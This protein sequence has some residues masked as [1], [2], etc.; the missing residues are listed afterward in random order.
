MKW[1]LR[2]EFGADSHKT[3]ARRCTFIPGFRCLSILSE[4]VMVEDTAGA[5][6]IID[7]ENNFVV[8]VPSQTNKCWL[9]F[10]SLT[11]SR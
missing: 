2:T 7:S 4:N 3:A 9:P 10:L 5:G 1:C 6:G 8:C 11:N